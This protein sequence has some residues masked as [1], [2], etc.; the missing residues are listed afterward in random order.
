MIYDIPLIEV[1]SSVLL[2]VGYEQISETL[3]VVFNSGSEYRYTGVPI[4]VYRNLCNAESIGQE[5]NR[6]IRNRYD[7]TVVQVLKVKRKA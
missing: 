6:T 7:C 3:R 5:F 1:K 4:Q 2:A